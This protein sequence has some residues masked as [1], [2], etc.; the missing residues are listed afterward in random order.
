MSGD[1][2]FW[3]RD[4]NLNKLIELQ[5]KIAEEV[6]LVDAIKYEELKYVVGVDQAFFKKEGEEYVV[7]AAVLMSFPELRIVDVGVDLRKVDF[8]YIPTFLMFREGD[9]AVEATKKVLKSKTVVIVDG[10]G[11]AHPRRCGLATFVGVKLKTPSIGV[12]KKPLYGK[13]EEP[14]ASGESKEITNGEVIG[15]AY[16]PCARCNPI[17]ISPGNLIT[18]ETALKI[19]AATVRNYRLPVP[20]REAHRI[21]NRE[22]LNYLSNLDPSG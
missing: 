16:K 18:P 21:A 10:S 20:I 3:Q 17:F 14:K 19:V 4:G 7:S 9:S 15:F 12:T 13:F 6:L 5:K 22:K 8:P 2:L 11:I 1:Q